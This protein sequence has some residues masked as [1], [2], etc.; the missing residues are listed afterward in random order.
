M[1]QSEI[2]LVS[3]VEMRGSLG[4][5]QLRRFQRHHREAGFDEV[6]DVD[7]EG[8]GDELRRALTSLFGIGVRSRIGGR[9]DASKPR[10]VIGMARIWCEPVG[11]FENV[12]ERA[13]EIVDDDD[14]ALT[15]SKTPKFGL[16]LG[17]A[18]N[19]KEVDVTVP[20]PMPSR[21]L[22]LVRLAMGR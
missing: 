8:I 4:R 11:N 22:E 7:V 13:A 9:E 12:F 16:H 14:G 15:T 1:Q 19:K 10:V 6:E 20:L 17:L 18:P 3:R 21:D 5:R 2:L